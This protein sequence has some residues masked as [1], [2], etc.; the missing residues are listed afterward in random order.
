M[1]SISDFSANALTG[2]P[3]ALRQFE[4]K[5]LLIVNTASACGFTPQYAGLETAAAGLCAARLFRAGLSLQPVRRAGARRCHGRSR[6]FCETNYHVT[7]PMFEKIDVNGADA[8]PLY[9]FLK[10]EKSGLLGLGNQM[11]FHQIPGRPCRAGGRAFCADH[12]T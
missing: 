4:G 1:T 9:N 2:E 11:E 6:A 12:Q 5:V 3:V 8:H 7:F 10:S